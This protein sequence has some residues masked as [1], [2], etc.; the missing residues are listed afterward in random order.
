MKIKNEL[1]II[2]AAI[3]WGIIS[4]F[5]NSLS[6]LNLPEISII[7][8]RAFWAVCF[9]G[10]YLLITNPKAF[11]IKL[12]DIWC[13]FGTGVLSLLFFTWCNFTCMTKTSVSVAV[14]LLYTSPVF[15]TVMAVLF[16]REK[17]T[18]TKIFALLL[19][20]FGCMLVTEVISVSKSELDTFGIITG[21]FAG[22]GYALY[23]IFS[24]FAIN[25]GYSSQTITFYTFL[26]CL[27]FAIPFTDFSAIS[28]VCNDINYLLSGLGIGVICCAMPYAL[29]TKGLV[30]V[31]SSKA[32]VLAVIEPVIAVL[33]GI[34]V[35]SESAGI[36][37]I[38]G[39]VLVLL[40]TLFLTGKE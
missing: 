33:T 8:T 21:L 36:L 35:F 16:F 6:Q 10:V 22:F 23:S 30:G 40:S 27:I 14:T 15:V 39:I 38:S 25:K 31:T 17:L 7:F 19:A 29:Y 37:K 12:K 4:I 28:F 1:Y 24:K 26:F 20:F 9:F 13:F 5:K 32:A 2:V 11:K 34:F 3:L 18:N